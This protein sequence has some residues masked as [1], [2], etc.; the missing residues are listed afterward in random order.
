[1]ETYT[2]DQPALEPDSYW[3]K[4]PDNSILRR[5]RSM[6]K[7]RSQPSHFE[8]KAEGQLWNHEGKF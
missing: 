7:P 5:M 8:L 6:I 3:I 4:F 2:I 1:M